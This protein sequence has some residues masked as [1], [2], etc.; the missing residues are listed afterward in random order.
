MQYSYLRKNFIL[1]TITFR[2][3]LSPEN[4]QKVVTEAFNTTQQKAVEYYQWLYE[5]IKVTVS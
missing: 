1:K 4:M 5:K 2:G 3:Q